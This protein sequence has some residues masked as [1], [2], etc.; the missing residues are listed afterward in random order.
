MK[1]AF[2]TLGCLDSNLQQVIEFARKNNIKGIEPRVNAD[3]ETFGKMTINDASLI[4]KAFAE[5]EIEITDLAI[6]CSLSQY[7]EKKISAGKSGIDFASSVGAMGVRVFVGANQKCFSDTD[8]SDFNGIVKG[9][10]ELSSYGKDKNVNIL[11]ETHSSFSSGQ[12]MSNLVNTINCDN[13][14]VIWDVL[15]SLEYRESP[16]QTVAFLGKKIV[17]VHLK[18][19]HPS[20]NPELTQFVHSDLGKGVLNIGEVKSALSKIGYNGYYSLEWESPWRDEIRDLYH[21]FNDLLQSYIR[22]CK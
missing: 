4:K 20:D 8:L 3:G 21:D 14:F 13:V 5:A 17:H 22:F 12:K 7:D 9:V 18:D 15:H 11:L 10:R 6:S 16:E 19:G 2:S 1:I